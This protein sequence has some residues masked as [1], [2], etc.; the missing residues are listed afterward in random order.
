[1]NLGPSVRKAGAPPQSYSPSAHVNR[2][3]LKQCRPGCFCQSKA[4][5]ELFHPTKKG[6][7]SK[8]TEMLNIATCTMRET[9]PQAWKGAC[10]HLLGW[11]CL[12]GVSLPLVPLTLLKELSVGPT[13]S[14]CSGLGGISML[15]SKGCAHS[16]DSNLHG[17]AQISGSGL[18]DRRRV[19]KE[20]LVNGAGT[21]KHGKHFAIYN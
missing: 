13:S 18:L 21:G 15:A 20:T 3:G 14:E 19:C 8:G 6:G 11:T 9:H 17:E 2:Y 16:F 5:S 10:A 1:M 12:L 4:A 7:L